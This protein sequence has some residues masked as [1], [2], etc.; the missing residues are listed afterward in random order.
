MIMTHFSDY[1]VEPIGDSNPY[2]RCVHCKRS[3]Q[4]I[5]GRIDGHLPDCE[6]RIRKEKEIGV[7]YVNGF[8]IS[9]NNY[10]VYA[11]KKA[12]LVFHPIYDGFH[13]LYDADTYE[14]AYEWCMSQDFDKW[15]EILL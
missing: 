15:S 1:V 10:G 8:E 12:Y 9:E 14:E 4:E 13:M 7:R 6:Y 11:D 2:Y 5:N 3:V